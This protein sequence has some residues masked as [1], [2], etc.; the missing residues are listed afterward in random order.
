MKFT[1]IFTT[2]ILLLSAAADAYPQPAADA[3]S[4][5]L[6]PI[7]HSK[8]DPAA[9]TPRRTTKASTK[10]TT[11]KVKSGGVRKTTAA[12]S[13][14]KTP[15]AAAATT[16]GKKQPATKQKGSQV[17][18]L[19]SARGGK[20]GGLGKRGCGEP[21]EKEK[22]LSCELCPGL[23]KRGKGQRNKN[24]NVLGDLLGAPL[25][26]DNVDDLVD[27]TDCWQCRDRKLFFSLSPPTYISFLHN[28][29]LCS[30]QPATYM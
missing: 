21:A 25:A 13:K 4:L 18:M 2:A 17:C 7:P 24:K 20:K 11:N 14:K 10:S 22:L 26:K 9:T 5:T 1:A 30:V 23:K 27:E 15:A 3:I 29:F 19:P 8:R 28:S 12:P 16:K 6:N